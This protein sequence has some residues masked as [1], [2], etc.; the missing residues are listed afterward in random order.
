MR[1]SRLEALIG[2]DQLHDLQSKSVMIFRLGGVGSFAIEALA[3]SAIGR[4]YL[5]DYDVVTISN[6]NR[7]LLA[8]SSTIGRPKTEVMAERIADIDPDIEVTCFSEKLSNANLSQFLELRP[9]WIVDAIDDV[10]MKIDLLEA[11]Q[12]AKI[13][14][15]SSMG[16]ANK[17]QPEK[18]QIATLHSTSVCPLAKVV[19]SEM[20]KRQLSLEV[21]V[22]FSSEKPLISKDPETKLASTAFVPPVAGMFLASIV[23]R[24]LLHLEEISS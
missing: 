8:L 13:P 22:V 24:N 18:V 16:F 2:P 20:K 5:I 10:K 23:I 14:I 17:I 15:V 11:C 6:I 1:Y 4:L 21:P 12:K 19:R 7:Q 9:D 3:R